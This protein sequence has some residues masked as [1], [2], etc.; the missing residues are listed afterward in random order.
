MLARIAQWQPDQ[1]AA[2]TARAVGVVTV[3]GFIA[4]PDVHLF[5]KPVVTQI[6][7]R[8]YGYDF[9]YASAPNWGTYASALEFANSVGRDVRDLRPRDMIDLQSFIWVL[10]SDEYP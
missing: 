10:G 5:V 1:G 4:R 8:A 6:A 3:F 7:A 2:A 9:T